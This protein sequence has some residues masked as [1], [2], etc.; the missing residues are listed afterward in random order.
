MSQAGSMLIGPTLI[1]VAIDYYANTSPW[2][3]V[4][5]VMLGLV[6]CLAYLIRLMNRMND[7]KDPLNRE[8]AERK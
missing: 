8:D 7:P 4:G 6:G 1:G 2:G 3:T 5:G